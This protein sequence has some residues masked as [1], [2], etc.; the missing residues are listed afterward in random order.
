[1]TCRSFKTLRNCAARERR[2][3]ASSQ[4]T[5]PHAG[6]DGATDIAGLE[7]LV[8]LEQGAHRVVADARQ[9][10]EMV[11]K[12]ARGTWDWIGPS[13]RTAPRPLRDRD[14]EWPEIAGA[15]YADGVGR[16]E[17]AHGPDASRSLGRQTERH[18]SLIEIGPDLA[19][20]SRW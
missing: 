15:A 8:R 1:M 5:A 19:P 17:V 9:P 11:R 16:G 13:R 14:P 20:Q 10:G 2:A 12:G 6:V 4:Q 7:Q 3:T 18:H